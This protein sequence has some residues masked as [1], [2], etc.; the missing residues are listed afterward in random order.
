MPIIAHITAAPSYQ[1]SGW[2][3]WSTCAVIVVLLLWGKLA[4]YFHGQTGAIVSLPEIKGCHPHSVTLPVR[5]WS[6]RVVSASIE[7]CL[8]C[9]RD[10]APGDRVWVSEKADGYV[11]LRAK[12]RGL[13]GLLEDVTVESSHECLAKRGT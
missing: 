2:L 13:R 6:G 1:D 10:L 8:L 11:V 5:L 3:F 12:G 4:S 9:S 7:G